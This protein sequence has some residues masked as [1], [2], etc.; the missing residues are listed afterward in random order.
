MKNSH[1]IHGLDENQAFYL[2][3]FCP[4]NLNLEIMHFGVKPSITLSVCK[5]F[6]Y[7]LSGKVRFT[8][9]YWKLGC[10]PS[11]SQ[12]SVQSN[13][14]TSYAKG[15]KCYFAIKSLKRYH[16]QRWEDVFILSLHSATRIIVIAFIPS[17]TSVCSCKRIQALVLKSAWYFLAGN[18]QKYIA[19]TWSAPI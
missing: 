12:S 14:L 9:N 4:P 19:I 17:A 6:K 18:G 11:L 10:H 16:S 7:F 8:R 15:K 13:E 1:A 5:R 3:F 2:I